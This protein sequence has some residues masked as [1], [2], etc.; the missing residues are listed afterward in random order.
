MAVLSRGQRI[1]NKKLEERS[2]AE[3]SLERARLLTASWK[4]TDG[5]PIAIRRGKAFEKIVSEIPIFIDDE[6]LLV[7]DFA[8]Q[9]GFAEWYPEFSAA[10]VL[11]D[12]SSE[13]ALQVFKV[14]DVNK[15]QMVE[16][17]EYWSEKC[18]ENAFFKYVNPEKLPEW[19]EMS[20]ENCY[21]QRHLSLLDRL[22]GYHSIN[23]EKVI[24]KGLSGVLQEVEQEIKT[25]KIKD[26]ESFNKVNF[27]NGCA[28]ALRGGIK[29]SKR[30]AV[31]AKELAERSDEKRRKE[32]LKIAEICN[33][34]PENPTRNFY[35]ALQSLWFVHVLEY[36][37]TRAEGESPGRVDQYLYPYFKNDIEKGI[38]TREGVVELLEC[39]RVKMSSLRQFSNKYFYEGTSG[40]PNFIT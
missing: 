25:T 23:Y 39:L 24:T 37:E 15:T 1:W 33:W 3:I 7:G 6:Q 34:V 38:I 2:K 31:L 20:E 22:G 4:T 8:A 36:L 40:E 26:N 32:L 27:L 13:K 30:Y 16:I 21:I 29:Y 11:K 14:K 5:L 28:I 9:S 19:I 10:W 35:E 18:V 12:V 17:A